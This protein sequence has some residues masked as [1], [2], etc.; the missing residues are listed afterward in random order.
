MTCFMVGNE[1]L[2]QYC[3]R[4]GIKYH[5][6]YNRLNDGYTPDEAVKSHVNGQHN[7]KYLINGK[8]AHRQMD[9]NT[10]QRYVRSIKERA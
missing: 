4:T 6:M 10:Y 9:K 8:P 2:R 5:T 7:L 3:K 1:T